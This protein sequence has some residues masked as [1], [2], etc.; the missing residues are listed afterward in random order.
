MAISGPAAGRL[1][2]A[3]LLGGPVGVVGRN[4]GG[5]AMA[6]ASV[7]KPVRMGYRI[8]KKKSSAIVRAMGVKAHLRCK[9]TVRAKI[10]IVADRTSEA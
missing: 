3:G 7:L 6:S 4:G 8:G 10:G 9:V 1:G 5:E 2:G